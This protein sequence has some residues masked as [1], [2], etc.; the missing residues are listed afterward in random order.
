MPP[1]YAAVNADP[2][3]L[4]S[5]GKYDVAKALPAATVEVAAGVRA[6]PQAA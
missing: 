6:L 2:S 4:I 1:L 5:A 3:A